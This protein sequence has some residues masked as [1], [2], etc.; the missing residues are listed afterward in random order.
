M[1][2]QLEI[3]PVSEEQFAAWANAA[4]APFF[5]E[6][7]ADRLARWRRRTELERTLGVFDGDAI[8]GGSLLFRMTLTVPGGAILPMGG[9]TAVGILPT[10]RRRGLL[11]RLIRQHF[12]DLRDWGEPLSGLYAAESS[13]YGR[14][15]YGSAAPSMDWTIDKHHTVFRPDVVL[16]DT[17]VRLVQPEE[18]IK[19]FPAIYDAVRAQRPGMPD[20]TDAEWQNWIGEDPAQWRD[21]MS[22]KYLALLGDRGYVVYRATLGDWQHEL[23][24][25]TLQV[26]EHMAVD[27]PAAARLWRFAF[28]HDLMVR[29]KMAHR[30]VDDPLPLLLVDPRGLTGWRYDGMW[31]RLMDVPRALAARTYAVDGR[32]TVAVTDRYVD[33]NTATWS[34]DAG[35]QGADC[36]RTDDE[37]DLHLDVADLA[38]AYLGAM[39]FTQLVR[40][41]RAQELT[42]GAARRADLMFVT[43][44]AAWCPQEY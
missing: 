35:P 31:L 32:V 29:F 16:D 17:P 19:A 33:A 41:G 14:Y 40:A 23:P 37:P 38:S 8:V 21:G 34:L 15:G 43:D 11:T 12:N 27:T 18:G 20:R 4:E 2:T 25:G 26:L 39:R 42:P 44:P 3:R 9:L 13:I 30:P 10:H 7:P 36:E 28:D 24:S 1:D 22:R 5:E 6:V